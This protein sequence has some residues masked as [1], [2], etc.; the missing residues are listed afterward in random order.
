MNGPQFPACTTPTEYPWTAAL[1]DNLANLDA[2]EQ[3]LGRLDALVTKELKYLARNERTEAARRIIVEAVLI[4]IWRTCVK[5]I[6]NEGRHQIGRTHPYLL[7]SPKSTSVLRFN[8]VVDRIQQI[9]DEYGL[10]GRYDTIKRLAA[11][12]VA[13]DSA[14][15]VCG[16]D[17]R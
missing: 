5:I 14:T 9:A 10:H 11:P 8:A 17:L 4:N 1:K 13:P 7:L 6:T 16:P 3:S 15:T 12:P 2:A